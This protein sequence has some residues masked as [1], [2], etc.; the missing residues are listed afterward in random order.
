MRV[1]NGGSRDAPQTRRQGC[2]RYWR[3]LG[4]LPTG[5][6]VDEDVAHGG[7]LLPDAVLDEMGD[8]VGAL[9]GHFGRDIDVHV[10]EV[11][12]THFADNTFLDAFD[13]SNGCGNE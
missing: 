5:F 13:F 1:R 10:H 3:G 8:L 4:M 2:L 6:D 9:Y 11:M 7:D 12:I